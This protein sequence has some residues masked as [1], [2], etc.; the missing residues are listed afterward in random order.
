MDKMIN[1][2]RKIQ[3]SMMNLRGFDRVF[4]KS[5]KIGGLLKT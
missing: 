3:N 4:Y 1:I 2:Q 5:T